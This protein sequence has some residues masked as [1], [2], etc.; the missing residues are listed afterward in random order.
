MLSLGVAIF[1]DEQIE[2]PDFTHLAHSDRLVLF[3]SLP[4]R[5]YMR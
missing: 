4:S 2:V 3:L 1:S 5:G